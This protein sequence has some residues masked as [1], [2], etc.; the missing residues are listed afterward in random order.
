VVPENLPSEEIIILHPIGSLFFAGVAELEEKL[1]EVGQARRT[2]VIFRFR[3]RDEVGSTFIRAIER[4]TRSLHAGGNL[5]MLAGVNEE[6]LNQLEKTDMLDLIG[7]EN[8]FPAQP[9]FGAALREALAAADEWL[10]QGKENE[11]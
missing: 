11:E 7:E 3:D 10:A 1:P 4:Y 9:Q 8:V 2:A 6:V 5:L